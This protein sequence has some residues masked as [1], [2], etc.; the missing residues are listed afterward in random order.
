MR[1]RR[2][3]AVVGPDSV[4]VSRDIHP[5]MA[6][7]P[8]VTYGSGEELT[9]A[10]SSLLSRVRP[11]ANAL[12]IHVAGTLVQQ[13]TL[14]DLPPA[15]RRA[16]VSLLSQHQT[17]YFRERQR[18]LVVGARRAKDGLVRAAAVEAWL[19]DSLLSVRIRGRVPLVAMRT[20]GSHAETTIAFSPKALRAR[21][22]S[23]MVKQAAALAS[24][25]FLPWLFALAVYST[26]L[27]MDLQSL[28]A[29][30]DSLAIDRDAL[31]ALREQ[32]SP[33]SDIVRALGRA[34]DDPYWGLAA[35]A[36]LGSTLPGPA[37][38]LEFQVEATRT[39]G[40]A[41]V[42]PEGLAPD[43]LALMLSRPWQLAADS[44]QDG[45]STR[46]V[47]EFSDPRP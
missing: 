2:A 7:D 47:L 30:A 31:Y 15:K 10:L 21:A 41:V 46:L 14:S 4:Q 38:L 20:A 9:A 22:R 19:I 44:L 25:A 11:K 17:R 6:E 35:V 5:P 42:A 34:T 36:D 16:L 24:L 26:D 32:V 29:A 33:A 39:R 45:S 13:R 18:P 40:R 23:W 37:Q 3:V 8:R 28:E 27:A 1:L 43:S 12:D